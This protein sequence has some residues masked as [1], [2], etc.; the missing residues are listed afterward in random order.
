MT[1]F[2][3]ENQIFGIFCLQI[4]LLKRFQLK[5]SKIKPQNSKNRKK[6][7]KILRFRAIFKGQIL[8]KSSNYL[9][10]PKWNHSKPYMFL[11]LH[12]LRKSKMSKFVWFPLG[13]S[14]KSYFNVSSS[15][16]SNQLSH[17]RG[18]P[19]DHFFFLFFFFYKSSIA[20]SQP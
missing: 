4:Y 15:I 18:T 9:K 7:P 8:T 2:C 17:T 1:N 12:L 14:K 19:L 10:L 3:S 6:F 20:T 11:K 5:N 16:M 13:N